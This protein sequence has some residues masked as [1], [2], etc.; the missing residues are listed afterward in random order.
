MFR[1]LVEVDER[2]T[3]TRRRALVEEIE[4]SA[5]EAAKELLREF[6][7]ARLLVTDRQAEKPTVEVA[8]EALLGKWGRLA[9]WIEEKR[10]DWRLLR[11]VKLAAEEW[12]QRS[13]QEAFRWPDERLQPVYAMIQRLELDQERELAQLSA[14]LSAASP[15]DCWK[16]SEI[17]TRRTATGAGSGSV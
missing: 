2:G 14:N 5:P 16:R 11:Q 8:H 6:T 4:R 9:N 7:K 12:E 1:R 13:P 3:A 15:S 17:R 10:D